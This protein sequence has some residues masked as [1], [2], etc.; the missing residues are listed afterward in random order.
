MYHLFLILK[1]PSNR[2]WVT[3]TYWAILAVFFAFAAR[4]ADVF[5]PQDSLPLVK[6]STL[7]DLLAIIASSMLAVSTFSLSIMVSA[8]SS[9]ANSVT[10]RATEVLMNDGAT[11]QAIASF[12]SAFIYA[13]IAKTALGTGFYEQNG[14]FLLFISTIIVLTYLIITLIRW[15]STLSQLGRLSNTL[16][17]I[18][19]ITLESLKNYRQEP[20]MGAT[21]EGKLTE[22][23]TPIMVDYTGYLTHINMAS[24][25]KYAEDNETYIH[26]PVRPGDLIMPHTVLAFVQDK[27]ENN[28]EIS[29]CFIL[30]RERTFTQDPCWGFLVFSEAAQRALSPG[31]NDPG[32]A[33]RVMAGIM[34]ILAEAKPEEESIE[35]KDYNRLSIVPLNIEDIIFDSFSPISRDGAATLE[36][37]LVM[38]KILAGIY[39]L[40]I[41]TEICS[42]AKLMAK[43]IVERASQQMDFVPDITKLQ[44]K[45]DE[46]FKS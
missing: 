33:M 32:T 22:N 6:L 9:A 5:L 27:P 26:I 10:P 35:K 45:H 29:N 20:N 40:P 3:P 14:K 12:I 11:R 13:I 38:L 8:F 39:H 44:K 21:W 18:Q 15:V 37:N 2:L 19:N 7:D 4:L 31:I 34:S 41:E 16:N 25:Q 17:K 24:L 46:L 42:A 43:Q 28:E 1:K 23:I 30:E 36:I